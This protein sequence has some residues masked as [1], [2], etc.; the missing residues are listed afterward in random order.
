VPDASSAQASVELQPLR[1]SDADELVGLLAESDLRVWLRARDVE[2]LRQRF[3]RWEVRYSPDGRERWLNWVFRSKEDGRALGWAQA[4]VGGGAAQVAY[5]T[6]PAERGHG[7]AGAAL[8]AVIAEL[9]DHHEVVFFEAHIREDNVGS[10]R[11][12]AA[13]GLKHT[14]RT[15]RGEFVWTLA[16]GS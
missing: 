7:Y 16:I 13:A 1:A 11:V 9:R 2:Q 4:T 8:R 15:V 3:E 12:A 6:L 10:Q 14:D 5:A